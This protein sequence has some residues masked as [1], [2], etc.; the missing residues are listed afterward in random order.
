MDGSAMDEINFR[1]NNGCSSFRDRGGEENFSPRSIWGR[2]DTVC[3]TRRRFERKRACTCSSFL[4]FFCG[5]LSGCIISLFC[6]FHGAWTDWL[7]CFLLRIGLAGHKG[8]IG[9]VD[10]LGPGRSFVFLVCPRYVGSIRMPET[11]KRT[12]RTG[13]RMVYDNKCVKSVY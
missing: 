6:C 9:R 11:K 7:G 5:R 10:A 13:W 4:F 8:I 1:N 12:T 3:M 2:T